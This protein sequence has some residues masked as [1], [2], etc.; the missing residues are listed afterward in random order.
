[1]WEYRDIIYLA[2]CNQILSYDELLRDDTLSEEDRDMANYIIEKS[3]E[4]RD[5]LE[6]EIM[7][8]DDKPISRPRWEEGTM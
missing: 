4:V 6:K 5:K 8:E 7:G 3:I 2:I 1:M